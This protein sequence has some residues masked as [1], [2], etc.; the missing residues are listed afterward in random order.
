[1]KVININAQALSDAGIDLRFLHTDD[2]GRLAESQANS[3]KLAEAFQPAAQPV[4]LSDER[5]YAI[6][7][8]MAEHMLT[9]PDESF[10][11]AQFCGES[12]RF[13]LNAAKEQA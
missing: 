9:M 12:V 3:K 6:L 1:M 11:E 13:I 4:V 7:H 5:C 10:T 2:A 8:E